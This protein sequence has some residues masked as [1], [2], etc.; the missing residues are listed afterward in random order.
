MIGRRLRAIVSH[1]SSAAGGS[2]VNNRLQTP[3]SKN[4]SKRTTRV[5]F[6]AEPA[7]A[8]ANR[9]VGSGVIDGVLIGSVSTVSSR[10]SDPR[11]LS[12]TSASCP[13][14][15][16]YDACGSVRCGQAGGRRRCAA[17]RRG[18]LRLCC[19]FVFGTLGSRQTGSR[20][21]TRTK[22]VV[23]ARGRARARRGG[24]KGRRHGNPL[25]NF[26]FPLR[27]FR[28]IA[29]KGQTFGV[30]HFVSQLRL[31]MSNILGLFIF[32]KPQ[33]LL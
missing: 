25:D 8:T 11:A 26:F 6:A 30:T 7:S 16:T 24:V 23:S 21:G 32:H 10:T 29:Q 31:S 27:R 17:L 9:L 12:S 33:R 2:K 19:P 4:K 5:H 22:F 13:P 1:V 3:T 15:R 20:R 28:Q 14:A 18:L